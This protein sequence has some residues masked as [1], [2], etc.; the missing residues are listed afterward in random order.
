MIPPNFK[1]FLYIPPTSFKLVLHDL[2]TSN[3]SSKT[4]NLASQTTDL[5]LQIPNQAFHTAN[6]TSKTQNQASQTQKPVFWT[7]TSDAGL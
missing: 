7:K 6:Q 2:L 1:G 5:D 4:P 3:Q